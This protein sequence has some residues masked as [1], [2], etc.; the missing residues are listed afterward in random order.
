[1]NQNANGLFNPLTASWLLRL[2]PAICITMR[3]V[4]RMYMIPIL[5]IRLDYL[6][7]DSLHYACAVL[8]FGIGRYN[9]LF[10]A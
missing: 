8:F 2:L 9:V 1:M 6:E 5:I 3:L 4:R 10:R 7:L